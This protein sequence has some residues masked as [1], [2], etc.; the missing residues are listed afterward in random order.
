MNIKCIIPI[1]EHNYW[2]NKKILA[3]NVNIV[4]KIG[5][6]INLA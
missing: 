6:T 4:E 5:N 1:D 3:A 2:S